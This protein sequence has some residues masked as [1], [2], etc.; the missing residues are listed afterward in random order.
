MRTVWPVLAAGHQAA[1][2]GGGEP[3]GGE[4]REG[5]DALKKKKNRWEFLA[6]AFVNC[7]SHYPHHPS[8]L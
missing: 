1:G 4:G 8:P 3:S 2:G 5:R 6:L 7:P